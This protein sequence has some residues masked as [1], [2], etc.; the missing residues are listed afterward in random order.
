MS[1]NNVLSNIATTSGYITAMCSIPSVVDATNN[2]IFFGTSTG[3]VYKYQPAIGVIP[4]LLGIEGSN[5]SSEI[6]AMATDPG[7][8]YV[9][10]GVPGDYALCRYRT[11]DIVVNNQ[12]YTISGTSNSN[13]YTVGDNTGGI[14]V[15]SQGE[16]F[17]VNRNGV[18]VSFFG[19][20]GYEKTPIIQYTD[21]NPSLVPDFRSL[22]FQANENKLFIAENN[23]GIVYYYDF[24]KD[25]GNIT[26]YFQYPTKQ[27]PLSICFDSNDNLFSSLAKDGVVTVRTQGNNLYNVVAG[28]GTDLV[29]TDPDKLKIVTPRAIVADNLGNLFFPSDISGANSSYLYYLSFEFV[30]R[31]GVTNYP[32]RQ[33]PVNCGLP[34]PGNCKK[35][36][37]TFSP[38]EY[39]GWGS[40][41]R[42]FLTPDPN[43]GCSLTPYVACATI[44]RLPIP[45]DPPPPEPVV[46]PP[47]VPTETPTLQFS[48]RRISLAPIPQVTNEVITILDISGSG[49]LVGAPAIGPLGEVFVGTSSGNLIKYET[50]N[51]TY[52]PRLEWSQNLGA[53]I[54]VS[55]SVSRKGVVAAFAGDTLYSLNPSGAILWSCNLPASPAGSVAFD[56]KSLIAAYGQYISYFYSNGQA[57]WIDKLQNP[58]EY[59]TVSP[60]IYA[61]VVFVG[62]NLGTMYC[63]DRDGNNLWAY[64]TGN[65][66]PITTSPVPLSQYTRVVFASGRTLY[67][68]NTQNPRKPRFDI[69]C[70]I[71]SITSIQSSPVAIMDTSG[72][73]TIARIFFTAN[74]SNL[75]N[76]ILSNETILQVN[77]TT[78]ADYEPTF[79][80]SFST[81]PNL[82][83]AVT[84]K[85]T[86][87]YI[88]QLDMDLSHVSA[89]DL[90]DK[91][92]NS[93]SLLL[94]ASRRLYALANSTDLCNGYLVTLYDESPTFPPTNFMA[95]RPPRPEPTPPP[96]D[97]PTNF[98]TDSFRI[99]TRNTVSLV[100]DSAYR[101]GGSEVTGYTI[102]VTPPYDAPDTVIDVGLVTAYTVG[103]LFSV[104]TY[105][106]TLRAYNNDGGVSDPTSITASTASSRGP[107]DPVRPGISGLVTSSNIP[108]SWTSG[109]PGGGSAVAGYRISWNVNTNYV[110]EW[111]LHSPTGRAIN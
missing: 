8:L 27:N 74:D 79:S 104:T 9:F 59:F 49:E 95:R 96:P 99:A 44:L 80:T 37:P 43:L 67:A 2:T 38:R 88:S 102:T 21:D 25:T 5:F 53:P 45:P 22:Q 28:E 12:V 55:P 61:S 83:H 20:Y 60:L 84:P 14:A 62:T 76:V 97:P 15:N 65:A 108:L 75:W 89:I 33:K 105:T 92:I 77:S 72:A 111:R 56:G 24:V 11:T 100:W 87:G 86:P 39:W 109:S 48:E 1:T 64:N 31:A 42:K 3:N 82:I 51:D 34:A 101:A 106:F 16:V 69:L 85:N 107:L 19:T 18:R 41:N 50:R 29:T 63:F 81:P 52:F 58:A 70:D 110:F 94:A 26:S 13:L 91:Y 93:E 32:P 71:S 54:T 90:S 36:A 66:S 73:D 98:E 47:V 57:I 10:V 40:P 46:I 4:L 103:D 7:G 6:R 68:I 30:K 35:P 78:T 23:L 17:F